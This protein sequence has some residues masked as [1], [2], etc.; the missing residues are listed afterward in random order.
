[1]TNNGD[2][3][4]RSGMANQGSGLDIDAMI[5]GLIEA[6]VVEMIGRAEP[7]EVEAAKLTLG[8]Q[9]PSEEI[10]EFRQQLQSY[11]ADVLEDGCTRI[12]N[13]MV[14]YGLTAGDDDPEQS[15]E[16]DDDAVA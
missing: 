10:L 15:E 5:D 1:M 6:A 3:A 13:G 2:D 12:L 14:G 4:A 7:T 16:K 11:L 8:L 9:Y